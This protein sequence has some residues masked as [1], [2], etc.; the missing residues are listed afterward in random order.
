MLPLRSGQDDLVAIPDADDAYPPEEVGVSAPKYEIGSTVLAGGWLGTV[1]ERW[2]TDDGW[3]YN[4]VV[5]GITCTVTE[6]VLAQLP[7]A[8]GRERPLDR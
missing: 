5:G 2:E 3:L 6:S 1:S 8:T 4:V 7:D